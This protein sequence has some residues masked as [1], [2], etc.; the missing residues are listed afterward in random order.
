M[1]QG[2]LLL[3]SCVFMAA[4]SCQGLPD[5]SSGLMLTRLY[6]AEFMQAAPQQ[7]LGGHSDAFGGSFNW[8]IELISELKTALQPEN[9]RRAGLQSSAQSS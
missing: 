7:Q 5:C 1:L 3:S 2:L 4:V 8:K 9:E 6:E